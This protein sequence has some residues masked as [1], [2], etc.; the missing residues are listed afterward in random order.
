MPYD[1]APRLALL[2][3]NRKRRHA[4]F[5]ACLLTVPAL[6]FHAAPGPSPV[7]QALVVDMPLMAK[8]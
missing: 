6:S 7:A 8:R 1:Y 5:M 4:F 2:A 3:R